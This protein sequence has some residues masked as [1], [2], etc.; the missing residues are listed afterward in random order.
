[1]E[2]EF[3]SKL[4]IIVKPEYFPIDFMQDN[5]GTHKSRTSTT[6][7]FLGR[8]LQNYII[9]LPAYLLA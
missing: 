8:N 7:N 9:L 4:V 2:S 5:F 6:M 3:T 1:M